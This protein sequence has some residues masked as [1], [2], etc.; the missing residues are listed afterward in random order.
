MRYLVTGGAGFVGSHVTDALVARGDRV[1]VLDD[2]STGRLENLDGALA[3]GRVEFVEGSTSDAT[4]V[5]SCMRTVDRCAHVAAAVGMKLIMSD[6]LSSLLSNVRGVDTVMAAA[7]RHRRRLLFVSTSEV[8]GKLV[9]PS[10]G[11]ESDCLFGSPFRSRWSY[12]IAKN[13][14][15]AA[16]HAYVRDRGAEIV[17]VRLFNAVGARRTGAYGMVLPRLVGQALTDEPLTVYGDGSQARCFTSVHDVTRGIVELFSIEQAV[18][19]A[20]NLG[21]SRP[22][23][24]IELARRVIE[25]TGSA[26]A[27][28][29]V[30]FEEVYGADYEELGGRVADSSA[31]GELMGWRT[32]RSLD[33]MIDEVIADKR[34]AIARAP[35]AVSP[36]SDRVRAA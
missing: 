28:R 19:H 25:R 11:E 34:A 6:P 30:P 36:L 14:G 8:Y 9:A 35:L 18:G 21:A 7:A 29:F 15:E 12:A 3:S 22:L 16:A 24:I 4:L 13:F 1:V 32:T 33:D 20:Y 27:I 23:E 2:L 5:E 26:S 31:V 17:V 10:L